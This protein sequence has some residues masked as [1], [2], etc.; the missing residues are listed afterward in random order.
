MF[1]LRTTSISRRVSLAMIL[2]V[3][4]IIIGFAEILIADNRQTLERAL[5]DRAS[6][7]ANLAEKSLPLPMW[8]VDNQNL[9]DFMEALFTD[10]AIVYAEYQIGGNIAFTT[11]TNAKRRPEFAQQ[12]WTFFEHSP[13]FL[14]RS[15]TI[16]YLDEPI[17][18][19]RFAVSTASIQADL[20]R[21]ILTIGLEMLLL[22]IAISLTSIAITSRSIIR[23]LHALQTSADRLAQG[24]LDQPIEIGRRDELGRLAQS[25]AAMR[26]AIREKIAALNQVN[27]DLSEEITERKYIAEELRH[28]RDHLEDLVQ[29]RTTELTTANEQLVLEIAERKQIEEALQQAK[30]AAE[31]ANQAKST[32]LAN[33]SHELRTPL[34]AILGFAQVMARNPHIPAEEQENLSIIQRNGDHLLTLINQVL[35]L[36]KIE[37]G[38]ITL[39]ETNF[40][41]YGLLDELEDLF[42]FRAAEKRLQLLFDRSPEIPRYVRTDD[43]KLRQ[44]LIN[45]LNN[46]IK[47]TKEG[48]VELRINNEELKMKKGESPEIL[49]S[50]FLILHF[51]VADTGPGIAPEELATVFEPFVQT[52]TGRDTQEGT[53]LGLSIS[54]KFV[55]LMGGDI[56]VQSEVGRGTTATFTIPCHVGAS[57]EQPSSTLVKRVKA[58]EPGQPRYRLLIV[59]E[60]PDNRAVLVKLLTPLGFELREAANGQEAITLWEKWYPHLI[61]M[62]LRMPFMGG[63]EA[64]KRIRNEELRMKNENISKTPNTPF[65]FAQDDRHGERSRTIII[66]LSASSFEEELSVALSKGCDDFLRKPFR[67][68]EIF[69]LLHKHLGVQFVYEEGERQMAKGEGQAD[70][71]V[72]TLTALAGL[73]PKLLADLEY[74]VTTTDII[75]ITALLAEIQQ[76]DPALANALR[77]LVEQFDYIKILTMLQKAVVR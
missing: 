77:K 2:V 51:S 17:G 9:N 41:L 70:Q 46:A 30:E 1:E 8:N 42:R 59:D 65:D 29:A 20:R 53:G 68:T 38:R 54:H 69:D 7:I 33:M 15:V 28:H 27:A 39:N 36:S 50:Q 6:I 45:L 26:D 19:I 12:S 71:D 74:A 56:T 67:E 72:L 62:D 60:H 52:K 13:Q 44:V 32:F 43:V 48:R 23:P 31:A 34:N 22:M 4:T 49:H 5:A 14:A 73:P 55:Q 61:W 10:P 76:Y 35:D 11:G 57:I 63:Y 24:Q 64:V 18:F 66:A 47:F 25:F 40:D 16:S 37:A 58:L 3:A 21:R 75:K